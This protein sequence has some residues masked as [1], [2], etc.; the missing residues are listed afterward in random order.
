MDLNSKWIVNTEDFRLKGRIN[1]FV[2]GVMLSLPK[3]VI[4]STNKQQ[5]HGLLDQVT[6]GYVVLHD[7]TCPAVTWGNIILC[8]LGKEILF[9]IKQVK[10]TLIISN[11]EEFLCS[12]YVKALNDKQYVLLIFFHLLLG[13]LNPIWIMSYYYLLVGMYFRNLI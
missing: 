5:A 7:M 12:L 8:H 4:F 2:Y 11:H 3:K 6:S 13:R 9:F 10:R 1:V